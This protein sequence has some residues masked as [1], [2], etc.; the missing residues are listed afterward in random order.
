[1]QEVF[2]VLIPW[3]G[4]ALCRWNF[5]DW[6][7]CVAVSV[8]YESACISL[9]MVLA[10]SW[11]RTCWVFVIGG[12]L[13]QLYFLLMAHVRLWGVQACISGLV[14]GL[15]D[16]T[17]QTYEG[18]SLEDV[19]TARAVRSSLCGFLAHGPLS[20]FYY[21]HLDRWCILN[22]VGHRRNF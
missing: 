8:R 7:A 11:V 5:L 19:D 21:Y 16:L 1:V 15:G 9:Q 14:Y 20:H 22:P 12:I 4:H 6:T 3:E 13:S 18:R 10:C 17:A 2:I